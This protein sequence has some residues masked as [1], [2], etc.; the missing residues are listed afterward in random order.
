MAKRIS[1]NA[2]A[3]TKRRKDVAKTGTGTFSQP[4]ETKPLPQPNQKVESPIAGL[5]R[6]RVTDSSGDPPPKRLAADT[7]ISGKIAAGQVKPLLTKRSSSGSDA[8]PLTAATV[9][10]K[11]PTQVVAKPSSFFTN[12]FSGLQSA[13]RS[14]AVNS[15]VA[16]PSAV[17][18]AVMPRYV[19]LL[20]SRERFRSLSY[21][22]H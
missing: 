11:K 22:S 9:A 14:A 17:N 5:K 8:N 19:L 12:N 15:A 21:F 13:K 20:S 6:P 4:K 16:K 18:K 3:A 1:D 10:S 2:T 7:A